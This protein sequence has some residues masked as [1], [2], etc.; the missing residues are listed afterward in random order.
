MLELFD[1]VQLFSGLNKPGV[2][3]SS[4]FFNCTDN[5]NCLSNKKIKQQFAFL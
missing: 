5:L 3:A 1:D 2:F 4:L